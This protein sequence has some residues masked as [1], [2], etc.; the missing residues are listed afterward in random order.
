MSDKH[1]SWKTLS[2]LIHEK[3]VGGKW[4]VNSLE[5]QRFLTLALC[6]EAGELANFVKKIWRGDKVDSV[7]LHKELA[8]VRIYLHLLSIALKCD[9]DEVCN[10][11]MQEVQSRYELREKYGFETP[12]ERNENI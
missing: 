1:W 12:E 6:G 10:Q 2:V 5:D 9:L 3:F 4:E 8:D 7:E 11:K